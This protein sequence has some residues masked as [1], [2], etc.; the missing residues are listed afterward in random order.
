ML[1]NRPAADRVLQLAKL[2]KQ[3]GMDSI[4]CSA[5]EVLTLKLASRNDFY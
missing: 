2:V 1:L 3:Y 4:V 5:H